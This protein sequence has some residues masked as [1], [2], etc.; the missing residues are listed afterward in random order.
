MPRSRRVRRIFPLAVTP[1]E[2]AYSLGVSLR[3]VIAAI[4]NG[5]LICYAEDN[6]RRN[7][8]IEDAVAWYRQT[9]KRV[10]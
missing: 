2:L 5:S 10:S 6:G 7:V 3:K 4:K 8:L 9:R 1:T